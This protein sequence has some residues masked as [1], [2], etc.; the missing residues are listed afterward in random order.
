MDRFIAAIIQRYN[1]FLFALIVVLFFIYRR[2]SEISAA[3]RSPMVLRASTG[4]WIELMVTGFVAA[5]LLMVL[6]IYARN[7]AEILSMKSGRHWAHWEYDD[8]EAYEYRNFLKGREVY[9]GR[10]GIFFPARPFSLL[11]GYR[12]ALVS[13]R[14]QLDHPPMLRLT[15]ATIKTKGGKK[16]TPQNINQPNGVSTMGAGETIQIPVPKGREHEA[17]HIVQNWRNMLNRYPL[18][19]DTKLMFLFVIVGYL[20]GAMLNLL[21]LR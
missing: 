18:L 10:R 6:V 8:D 16:A 2:T 20:G 1:P 13:V 3:M 21:V 9:I 12:M 17:E 4:Y 7:Y 15:Y 11:F 5:P 19:D 14:A